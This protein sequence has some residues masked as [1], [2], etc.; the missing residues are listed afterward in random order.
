MI[1][2]ELNDEH[3]HGLN[4]GSIISHFDNVSKEIVMISRQRKK[5]IL[6]ELEY[7]AMKSAIIGN[8]PLGEGFFEQLEQSQKARDNG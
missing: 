6:T 5:F 4:N 2:I 8:H 1:K 7:G 3:V